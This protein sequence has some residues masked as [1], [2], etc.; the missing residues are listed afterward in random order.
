MN[1]YAILKMS[2]GKKAFKFSIVF[3]VSPILS[4]SL[5]HCVQQFV[6]RPALVLCSYEFWW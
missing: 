4:L 6:F 3:N 5:S 2:T 1:I